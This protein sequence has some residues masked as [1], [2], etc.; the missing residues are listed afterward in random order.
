MTNVRV[1]NFH[2]KYFNFI[3]KIE[4]SIVFQ[5]FQSYMCDDVYFYSRLLLHTAGLKRGFNAFD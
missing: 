2:E 3:E 5:I 4:C 1:R